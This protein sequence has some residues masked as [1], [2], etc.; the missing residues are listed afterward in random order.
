M[1]EY[2]EYYDLSDDIY[3]INYFNDIM[4]LKLKEEQLNDDKI[5]HH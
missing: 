5:F 2:N 3:L 4:L 1:I